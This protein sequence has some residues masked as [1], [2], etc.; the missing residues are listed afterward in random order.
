MKTVLFDLESNGLLDT[1]ST[2]HCLQIGDADGDDSVVYTDA[3]PGFPSI[4]EGLAR[5]RAAD[6]V[7]GHHILG[8]DFP[9]MERF[10][11][12]TLHREQI[13]DTLVCTRLLDP[14]ER[15]NTL[16]SWGERLG[17]SKGEF[18]GPWDTLTDEM[19]E[20][21][22]TDIAVT[23]ALYKYVQLKLE[24]WGESVALEHEIAWCIHLQETNGFRFNV[25]GAQ[26]LDATLRGEMAG[27]EAQL[28]HSFTPIP[29]VTIAGATNR[30]L[31]IVKGQPR[32]KWETF[33]PGSRHHIARRLQALGWR[34]QAYGKDGIPTVDEKV[35]ADLP[36]PEA[37]LLLKYLRT[38]KMLGMLSDGKAGW[39][40]M[41][42]PTGRIHGRVN[43][44][45]AATGRMTH[46]NPNVAQA[47]SDPRMRALWLPR[48]GWKLVGIDASSLEACML[49]HYLAKWDGGAYAKIVIEG[50]EDAGTD[51]HSRNRDVLNKMGLQV[52]RK[53]AK[54]LLYAFLYGAGDW[55]LAAVV[56]DNLRS[57]GKP[58]PKIPKK[59]MGLLVRK[60]LAKAVTGLDKLSAAVKEASKRGYL[61]GLDGRHLFV[62]SDHAALNTL[63]QGAGAVVMKR[64]LVLFLDTAVVHENWPAMGLC[65]NVHDEVQIEC[66]P[67]FAECIGAT[68][69]DC[70]RAAGEYYNLRCPL[71]GAF[72]VGDNWSQTH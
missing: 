65:A 62:R 28:R 36:W 15:T 5:L 56:T 27:L 9:V 32:T 18:S 43:P 61:I 12:G 16:R 53:G 30:K 26:E 69:A 40:K 63:L 31:G 71:S 37:Q 64:A 17:V 72:K 11:P 49:A 68:F 44:N 23:R 70:I 55:K 3:R 13:Y 34:P 58:I 42:K 29:H 35:L 24:D 8:F 45:G 54:G 25:Q 57:Q 39:L 59:E 51:N 46:S 22:K 60:G 4:A 14:E 2:V 21:A 41:V 50:D 33:E 66:E 47:D 10:Y 1:I 48:E 38:Q 52:N 20:Y 7:V 67:A 19:I 6:R